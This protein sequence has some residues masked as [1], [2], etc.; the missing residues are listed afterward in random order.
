MKACTFFGHRDTPEKI[1]PILKR[2]I[3]NLIVNENV[4]RFYV[5]NQGGFDLMCRNILMEL[6]D[7]Y[8]IKYDVVLAY[9]GGKNK[10]TNHIKALIKSFLTESKEHRQDLLFR[11]EING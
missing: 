10:T 7:L 1:E 5:G 2:S 6:S 3:I 11:T 8:D 4:T 9:I